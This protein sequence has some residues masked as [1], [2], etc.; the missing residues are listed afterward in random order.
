MPS[1]AK[2]EQASGFSS[3][4]AEESGASYHFLTQVLKGASPFWFHMAVLTGKCSFQS[5]ES[6]KISLAQM[7]AIAPG[8]VKGR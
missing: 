7:L 8:V 6:T 3:D 1:V 4:L 5:S 2:T